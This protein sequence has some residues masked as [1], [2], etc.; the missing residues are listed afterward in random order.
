LVEIDQL[1]GKV[2]LVGVFAHL[3]PSA[4]N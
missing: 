1:V 2:M 3:D 4:S